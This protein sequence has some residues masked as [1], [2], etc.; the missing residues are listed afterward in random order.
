MSSHKTK[1]LAN[2]P[3]LSTMD[4]NDETHQ[5]ENAISICGLSF[6][7]TFKTKIFYH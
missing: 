3:N 5:D 4:L 7:K 2:S 6:P 1:T